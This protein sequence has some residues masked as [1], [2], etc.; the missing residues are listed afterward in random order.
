MLD[1]VHFS[2]LCG[3]WRFLRRYVLG[4]KR[5]STIVASGGQRVKYGPP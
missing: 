2:K 4:K 3:P 1:F 5:F